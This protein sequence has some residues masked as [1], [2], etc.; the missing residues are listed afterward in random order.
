MRF[1]LSRTPIFFFNFSWTARCSNPLIGLLVNFLFS[2]TIS[3]AP[4]SLPSVY[5]QKLSNWSNNPYV[6][7][8]PPSIDKLAEN[9]FI[10]PSLN[11]ETTSLFLFPLVVFCVICVPPSLPEPLHNRSYEFS[12]L[13]PPSPYPPPSWFRDAS[14]NIPTITSFHFLFV[15]CTHLPDLS[16]YP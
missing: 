9:I 14:A 5:S 4:R 15:L 3:P 11:S 6:R 1:S 12:L 10:P 13:Q 8:F 16:Q 7:I 2:P